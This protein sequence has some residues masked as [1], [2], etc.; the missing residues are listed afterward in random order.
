MR[1]GNLDVQG[2]K[3]VRNDA[4]EFCLDDRTKQAAW[5]ERYGR[6]SNV[7]LGPR[8]PSHWEIYP[9]E[10]PAPH[11]PLE[12][13]IMAIK[14]MKCG[15][16]VGTSLIV[17][18]MLKA[19]GVEGAQQIRDLIMDIIHFGKIPTKCE[20]N[21]M[22]SLYKGKGV[23]LEW[24]NYRGLKLLDQLMKVLER[25]AENFLWQQ[26][27]I[28]DMQFGFMPGR[29]TTYAIFIVHQLQ[30]KFYAT[31]K[32]LY[33]AFVDLEKTFDHVPRRVIW[34][35]LCKLSVEEWLVRLTQ[36]MYENA[37]SR[38]HVSCNLS[39]KFSVKVGIHQ[40]SCLSPLLFITVPEALSQEFRIGCPWVNLYADDLVIITESLEEF[41]EKVIIWKTKWKERDF[42]STW[43]KPRS[44][45]LGQGWMCFRSLRKTPVACVLR[46]RHKFHFLWWSFQ[47]DPQELQWY[48]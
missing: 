35:A 21:T 43:A 46:R 7:R 1:C 34:R 48:P 38:M 39:E 4:G 30:E 47:L 14:L 40:G 36:T 12:L 44:W 3:P 33:M 42:G 22:V 41:Q 17:A 10:G 8:T 20:E 19:S 25:V 16:V 2:E 18:E 27:R 26:V 37:R 9:M 15:K 6:L 11:I 13:V 29:S 45:Y 28:D 24:V 23:P 5:K 32:T 31:N